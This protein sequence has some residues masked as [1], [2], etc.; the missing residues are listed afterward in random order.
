M[1]NLESLELALRNIQELII[2]FEAHRLGLIDDDEKYKEYISN[3]IK[4]FVRIEDE[5]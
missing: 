2:I 3:L 1:D 5:Q 4:T